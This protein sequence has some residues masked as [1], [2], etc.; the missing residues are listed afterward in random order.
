VLDTIPAGP[1]LSC[2][3]GSCMNTILPSTSIKAFN[4]SRYV[5]IW[6]D[7]AGCIDLW[8]PT[9]TNDSYVKDIVSLLQQVVSTALCH[10]ITSTILA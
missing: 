9:V 5:R 3:D 10:A 4:G 1:N 7:L 6:L 2:L 8:D